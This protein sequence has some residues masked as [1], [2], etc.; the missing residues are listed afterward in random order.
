MKIQFILITTQEDR[1]TNTKLFDEDSE[2]DEVGCV[3][4]FENVPMMQ[5]YKRYANK[6]AGLKQFEIDCPIR[7]FE[8]NLLSK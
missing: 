1:I 8:T 4:E 6:I 5:D 7:R 2:D 3:V